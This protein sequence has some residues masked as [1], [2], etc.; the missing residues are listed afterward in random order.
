ME[1]I[2]DESIAT[3]STAASKLYG[4][5]YLRM[6]HHRMVDT[7]ITSSM[8]MMD[9]TTNGSNLSVERHPPLTRSNNHFSEMHSSSDTLDS[10]H[11]SPREEDDSDDMMTSDDPSNCNSSGF[12]LPPPNKH[13]NSNR[14]RMPLPPSLRIRVTMEDTRAIINTSR[15]SNISA[16]VRE[17]KVS[18]APRFG[19]L[20]SSGNR[21]GEKVGD[22]EESESERHLQDN[23]NLLCLSGSM[24]SE[25]LEHQQ[26]H[27]DHQ[28]EYLRHPNGLARGM[29]SPTSTTAR[30]F[31]REVQCPP[32]LPG[33]DGEREGSGARSMLR[34]RRPPFH[35]PSA[36]AATS[37]NPSSQSS[38]STTPPPFPSLPS[39]TNNKKPSVYSSHPTLLREHIL[40]PSPSNGS[41]PGVGGSFSC[42]NG[43]RD[44]PVISRCFAWSQDSQDDRRITKR[45][46]TVQQE[47]SQG[48]IASS[49]L[50]TD[51]IEVMSPTSALETIR[52]ASADNAHHTTTLEK[53]SSRQILPIHHSPSPPPSTPP[54]KLNW[55]E[56]VEH[57]NELMSHAVDHQVR[58]G[59]RATAGDGNEDVAMGDE[60]NNNAIEDSMPPPITTAHSASRYSFD[61][62]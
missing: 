28:Q 60:S 31:L 51:T 29:A 25:F 40:S 20:E 8:K 17:E 36:A 61:S 57:S 22:G 43:G 49:P 15:S 53:P 56:K 35:R 11:D 54:T 9:V 62:L 12:V 26:H 45:A 59:T 4:K 37:N 46:R 23:S 27:P 1:G 44:K 38:F 52:G 39:Q 18:L 41:I 5:S 42:D 34:Y 19:R 50:S 10:R 2:E 16:F 30:D 14:N 3:T 6:D 33:L 48:G 24:S 21:Q 47:G 7:T 58:F 13:S 32:P 55:E